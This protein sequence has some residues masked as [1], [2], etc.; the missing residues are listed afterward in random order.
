MV[1]TCALYGSFTNANN[2]IGINYLVIVVG[3]SI[4]AVIYALSKLLPANT[5]AKLA[6]ITKME[7]TQLTISAI[8]VAI[9]VASASMVCSVSVSISSSISG[10]QYN[11]FV[12]ATSY[13][14]NL[15]YGKGIGLLTELYTLSI[16]Y[17]IYGNMMSGIG[18]AVSNL[19]P[20]LTKQIALGKASVSISPVIGY[21][22]GIAFGV[23]AIALTGAF[24]PLV[25]IS[26]GMLFLQYLLIPV[27]EY[28]AFTIVLPIAIA[29]RSLSFIGAGLRP[30]ANAVLA[31]AIAMYLIY[32]MTV[33]FDSY[34]MSWI[35]SNQN[36]SYTFLSSTYTHPPPATPSFFSST[37]LPS[38]DGLTSPS[39]AS[40][41]SS[42]SAGGFISVISFTEPLVI[43]NE[44]SELLFQAVFLFALNIA[45]TIGFAMSLTN[46]LTSGIEGVASFW[47]NI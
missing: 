15:I 25:I 43:V 2:W 47:S 9:L 39:P 4:V 17:T 12:M 3:L 22:A 27:I 11:P 8:I 18:G 36:P 38:F 37:G 1:N 10:N 19:I 5:S 14:G 7:I 23:L 40:I 13:I 16:T 45:I 33:V 35:F 46:A 29:M 24:S 32:P 28:T 34:A 41:F 42:L 21:D 26:L 30:A 31:I 20:D 44:M 6:G